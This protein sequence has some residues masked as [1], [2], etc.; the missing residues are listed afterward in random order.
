MNAPCKLD[1]GFEQRPIEPRFCRLIVAR[2]S[3]VDELQPLAFAAK[4]GADHVVDVSGGTEA[5]AT[6]AAERR[7][8]GGP[9]L[10]RS[11]AQAA[12]V[13]LVAPRPGESVE[14]AA[15]PPNERWW[16]TRPRPGRNAC[17]AVRPWSRPGP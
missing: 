10:E 1:P 15:P 3:V 2:Q 14:P 7:D 4:L 8:P 12:G 6:L 13:T 16:P 11:A 5:L 17:A 9:Y